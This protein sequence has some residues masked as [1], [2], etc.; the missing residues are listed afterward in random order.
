VEKPI[1]FLHAA[2]QLATQS[3]RRLIGARVQFLGTTE[4]GANFVARLRSPRGTFFAK[5]RC[6]PR[7]GAD[8]ERWALDVLDGRSAPRCLFATTVRRVLAELAERGERRAVRRLDVPHGALLILEA[9]PGRQHARLSEVDLSRAA[10][11]LSRLH[12]VRARKGPWLAGGAT[13]PAMARYTGECLERLRGRGVFPPKVARALEQ[14]LAGARKQIADAWWNEGE[15]PRTIC[16][17][18]AR[19]ANLLFHEDQASL[20]DFEYAG[21]GDPVIDLARFVANS[22]LTKYEE[23]CLLDS[24]AEHAGTE[25]QRRYFLC[26]TLAP[27]FSVLVSIRYLSDIALGAR[28]V[29]DAGYLERRTPLVEQRLSGLLGQEIRLR[30]G[31]GRARR[32]QGVVAVDG[33]AGSGKTPIAGRLAQRL[34]VAHINTGAAYRAAALLGFERGLSSA[35]ERDVEKLVRILETTDLELTEGGAIRVGG[36]LLSASLDILPI[37]ESVAGW[38]KLPPI[39][40]ALRPV[41]DRALEARSAVVE[42]R[43]VKTVLV[44]DARAS[45]YVEVDPRERA[46]LIQARS[47]GDGKRFLRALA[48][49][50]R[51]DRMRKLAPATVPRG[52]VRVRGGMDIER[53]VERMMHALDER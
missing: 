50:D 1:R 15:T 17:G 47:G 8:R 20:I 35:N 12:A 25:G 48:A 46:L 37:E 41:L 52:A 42:G 22:A 18:D 51:V 6:D 16:H 31:S 44:P 43:D 27:L 3:D 5:L 23:L 36:R 26:R 38:A 30:L 45:F 11:A 10:I 32:F 49:R 13:V 28:R 40:E 9:V 33:M 4:G 7:E 39:R 2:L 24:Y 53:A 21:L 34:G 29:I 19:P 14:S